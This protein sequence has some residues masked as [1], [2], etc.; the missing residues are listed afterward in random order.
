M[1]PFK[2]KFAAVALMIGCI[3]F[4]IRGY[5]V[6][7][8]LSYLYLLAAFGYGYAA[9]ILWLEAND[10]RDQIV[11]RI[12]ARRKSYQEKRY[13]VLAA[14]NSR[15]DPTPTPWDRWQLHTMRGNQLYWEK[16]QPKVFMPP[17]E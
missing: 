7:T 17:L 12:L 11:K 8:F 16:K 13:G 2:K 14:I 15:P 10:L 4:S 1:T 5:T 3:G 9:V 6:G